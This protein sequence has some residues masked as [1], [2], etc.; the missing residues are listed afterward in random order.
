[1]RKKNKLSI[2]LCHGVFDLVHIG[3]I[4]HFIEAK[5]YCDHL[6]VSI[7]S[8]KFV[9]KSK[10]PNKPTFNENERFEILKNLKIVDEVII[11]DYETAR[12]SIKKIKPNFYFKGKDYKKS[13]DKNLN[14]EKKLVT[15]FGGKIIFTNTPLNSSSEIINKK[16]FN[17]ENYFGRNLNKNAKNILKDKIEKFCNKKIN[18]KILVL[19]EHILDTYVSTD[20]QGKSGK[21]N[22]LTSSFVSSKSYGGGTILVSNLLSSFMN[23]VDNICLKNHYNDKIYK[24]FLN[25]NVNKINFKT[26]EKIIVKKRFID[27]YLGTK[28]FQL[29]TNQEEILTDNFKKKFNTFFNKINLK[30]YDA[31]VIFDYGHGLI[32]NDII[33]KLSKFKN[34]V[35]INCQSNSFN[36]GYNLFSKY[37]S[38]KTISMDETE[39]RLLAQDK[40]MKINDLVKKNKNLF[41]NFKSTIITLG[42]FG[43]YHITKKNTNFIK[44]VISSAKDTTGCGDVFFSIYILLDM[45]ST[46]NLNE[47]IILCHLCAGIHAEYDGN[48]NKITKYN[49]LKFAKSY[50]F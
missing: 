5:K 11:S 27:S 12:D 37:K 15:S 36:F 4:R 7:T 46:L 2:G 30:K 14:I 6:I 25:K 9:K 49:L 20:V 50:L 22:I 29:N 8:D 39:F 45:Y 43:A 32:N 18:N 35:Y 48:D 23:K 16:F 3:H 34:K 17:V 42:K 41:K 44:S 24:K 47:K 13:S 33:K 40:Y 21:N 31:I 26:N 28:L 19:G 38:A 10:G 1:M